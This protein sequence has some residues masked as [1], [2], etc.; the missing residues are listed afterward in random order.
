MRLRELSHSSPTLSARDAFQDP[1]RVPEITDS[2][3]PYRYCV[4]PTSTYL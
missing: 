2:I 4:F 3:E 1:R